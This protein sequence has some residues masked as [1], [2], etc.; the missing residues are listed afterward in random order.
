MMKAK[1]AGNAD[2]A[3]RIYDTEFTKVAP[4]YVATMQ[5]YLDWEYGL[6]EQLRK[7]GSHHFKVV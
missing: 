4:V 6:V 3:N 1:R 2:E 7:D 5:A